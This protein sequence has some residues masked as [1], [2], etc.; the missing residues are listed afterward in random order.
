MQL[1]TN[2]TREELIL[3]PA[4]TSKGVKIDN[5]PTPAID[6]NLKNLAVLVLQPLKDALCKKYNTN[7]VIL[8]S[9]GYRCPLYNSD[10]G[11]DK[12]SEHLWGLASD[13]HAYYFNTDKVKVILTNQ[14]I[15]DVCIEAKIPYQQIIFHPIV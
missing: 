1:T 5:T 2:F 10:I 14:E 9:C 7:V 8:A 4:F 13:F 15:I 11:G 6:K 3:A 12:A